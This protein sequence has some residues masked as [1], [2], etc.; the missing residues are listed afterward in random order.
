MENVRY[1]RRGEECVRWNGAGGAEGENRTRV[2][3][4]PCGEGCWPFVRCTTPRCG[5]EGFATAT[6]AEGSGFWGET[7]DEGVAGRTS[8]NVKLK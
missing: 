1:T 8:R 2:A 5:D 4:S 7:R 6:V 3:W